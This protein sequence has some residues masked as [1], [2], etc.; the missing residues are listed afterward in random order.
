VRRGLRDSAAEGRSVATVRGDRGGLSRGGAR[1][2]RCPEQRPRDSATEGRHGACPAPLKNK[3]RL[4]P[5]E[6][7]A[8]G[9]RAGV[10][11]LLYTVGSCVSGASTGTGVGSRTGLGAGSNRAAR[12]PVGDEPEEAAGDEA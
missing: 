11:L 3:A 5:K 12:R 6:K 4:L 1:R 8:T 10:T 2:R 7:G 9:G